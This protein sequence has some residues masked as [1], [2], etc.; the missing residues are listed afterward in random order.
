[1]TAIASSPVM[2]LE[3]LNHIQLLEAESIHIIR[4]VASEFQKPVMLYSIGKDSSV[5]LRLAQ[6]AF[7]PAP[8]PF[9][10]LHVD[11]GYKFREMLDFRDNYTSELGLKLIVWRNEEALADGANPIRLGTQR[12]C[13]LLKTQA[14]STGSAHTDL[15]RPLGRTARRRKFARQRT[16]L[17]ISRQRRPMGS[18]NQRPES[19]PLQRPHGPNES[20]R[21]FPLRTGPNWTSGTTSTWRRSRLC[22]SIQRRNAAC[23]CAATASSRWSSRLYR[24][25]R[26]KSN[27]SNAACAH[28]DAARAR[29]PSAPMPIRFRRLLRS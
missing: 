9:P 22:R 25:C 3:R 8:I 2:P 21:V 26:A 27:G 5:M 17:L 16:H 19:G 15:T 12:C 20:I 13:G 23:W 7:H 4:E 14:L 24:D 28:S 1:M 29:E 11:T 10:L 18:E 6:K